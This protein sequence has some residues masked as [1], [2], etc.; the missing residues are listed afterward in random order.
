MRSRRDWRACPNGETAFHDIT[1]NPENWPNA[2]MMS[3]VN[4]SAKY[5]RVESSPWFTKG[6]IATAGFAPISGLLVVDRSAY[7]RAFR[8]FNP[9]PVPL[10][11]TPAASKTKR[12]SEATN[13]CARASSAPAIEA[14]RRQRAM[15]VP[16]RLR[17][18]VKQQPIHPI[19]IDNPVAEWS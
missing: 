3:C 19:Q 6:R 5:S 2:L 16:H 9:V 4:P 10:Q 17:N 11:S 14:H 18:Q 8:N 7:P 15:W 12:A 1:V 13:P